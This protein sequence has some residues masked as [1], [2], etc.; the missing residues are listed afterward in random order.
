MELANEKPPSS[1]N[2]RP[3]YDDEQ[4]L[5]EKT[6]LYRFMFVCSNCILII[7]YIDMA[8]ILAKMDKV[9]IDL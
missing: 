1:V 7:F 3:G 6:D 8:L 9:V 5:D 2:L 4:V